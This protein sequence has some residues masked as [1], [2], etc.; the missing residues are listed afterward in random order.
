ML[1]IRYAGH[2][3]GEAGD[4]HFGRVHDHPQRIPVRNVAGCSADIV[5]AG[6]LAIGAVR[7]YSPC[8]CG[9]AG[10]LKVHSTRNDTA[11]A[12]CV[13]PEAWLDILDDS[14]KHRGPDGQGRFRDRAVRPDGTVMDVALVHRR[15]A[16]IDPATGHSR[17]FPSPGPARARI[18]KRGALPDPSVRAAAFPR[19]SNSSVRY[20]HLADSPGRIAVA[21][22]GCV[23]HTTA[24][25]A[26]SFLPQGIG[27][28]PITQDTEVLLHGWCE[29][30]NKLADRLVGMVACAIWDSSLAELFLY[31]SCPGEHTAVRRAIGL[32][33][34]SLR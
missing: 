21:F 28:R 32:R 16:I 5:P 31:R 13:D 34:S 18:P 22:N 15:L 14:I 24:S 4:H 33:R 26:G 8:M 1:L 2:V 25:Y 10:I 11:A 30:K 29:W 27:S 19:P 6:N 3:P 17:W 12:R 20:S 7:L 9:I 23:L